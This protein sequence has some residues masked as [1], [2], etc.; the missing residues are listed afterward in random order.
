M[1]NKLSNLLSYNI[2]DT[3]PHFFSIV[4]DSSKLWLDWSEDLI[5]STGNDYQK[6]FRDKISIK[7]IISKRISAFSEFSMNR[8]SW[9]N[10]GKTW[11]VEFLSYKERR[12]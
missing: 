1:K 10:N 2:N 9:K 6:Y 8:L 7:T 5:V 11:R 4:N 3:D 12:T